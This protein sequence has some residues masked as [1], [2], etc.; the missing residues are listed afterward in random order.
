MVHSRAK[1]P[2]VIDTLNE[3][4][5]FGW[6]W[7][8]PPYRYFSAARA[9]TPVSAIALDGACLRGKCEACAD[10]LFGS[11]HSA[12]SVCALREGLTPSGLSCLRSGWAFQSSSVPG[13]FL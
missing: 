7:L 12:H 13:H 8:V 6:S 3:G 10:G 11:A 1:G 2:V 5:V 4:E 9:V